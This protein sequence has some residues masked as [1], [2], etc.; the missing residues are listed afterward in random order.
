MSMTVGQYGAAG[1]NLILNAGIKQIQ[2]QQSLIAW[3][4]SQGTSSSSIAG[5]DDDGQTAL[6]LSP[7]LA[8]LN[9]YQDNL[10]SIQNRLSL[11]STALKQITDLAQ[12]LN[13]QLLGMLSSEGSSTTSTNA[14]AGSAQNGLS[15]LGTILN[16]T[17]GNGFIFA[18]HSPSNPPVTSP[19]TLYNSQLA[20]TISG[21]VSGLTDSNSSTILSQ[22]TSASA[23]NSAGMSVF[24]STLS[25]PADQ[26]RGMRASAI[27]GPD[28]G[29]MTVGIV[30][31]E[32]EA[33]SSTS[34]GSPIRDLMRDMMV[35]SSMKG[36]S[37]TTPGFTSLVRQLHDSLGQTTNQLIDMNSGIGVTQNTLT[38]QQGIFSSLQLTIKEQLSTNL[39]VNLADV[40]SRSSDLSLQLKASFSLIADT[41]TMSLADYI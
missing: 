13:T 24:S 27:T 14:A 41:K 15:S 12:S 9:S 29:N 25:L 4:T 19:S 11:S 16:T 5:L 40:A 17:D 31:T 2:S 35:M 30:A 37:N 34:T 6:S 39:N 33:A 28:D 20:H 26:A 3:Q 23:D 21:L 18:G 22:A 8:A 38:R 36:M 10:S 7:K 32:G 1:A